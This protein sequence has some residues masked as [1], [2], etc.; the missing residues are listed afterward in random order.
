MLKTQPET[1][2]RSTVRFHCCALGERKC[3][4]ASRAIKNSLLPLNTGVCV[5][6]VVG[7]PVLLFTKPWKTPNCG[8]NAGL[9]TPAGGSPENAGK[10]ARLPGGAGPNPPARN[11]EEKPRLSLVPLSSRS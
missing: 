6:S 9:I 8:V 5:V 1:I 2:S 10:F 11:G 7:A 3:N 4:G